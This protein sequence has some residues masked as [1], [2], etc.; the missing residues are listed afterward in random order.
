MTMND[1]LTSDQLFEW[2]RTQGQDSDPQVKTHL[3]GCDEC[4]G[5]ST[6]IAR[7]L[8]SASAGPLDEPPAAVVDRAMAIARD[9]EVRRPQ[10][11]KAWSLGR[12]MRDTLVQP[13]VAGVRGVAVGQRLLYEAD[14][15]HLDLE[16][17]AR[18]VGNVTFR[19]QGQVILPGDEPA[20]DLLAVLYRDARA[21]TGAEGDAM[22]VFVLRD[23]PHGEYRLEVW[24]METGRAIRIEPVVVG[25]DV[26]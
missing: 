18:G 12:L 1:H 13:A 3:S 5:W 19:V 25:A 11:G 14:G 15:A 26:E 21:V 6:W 7:I 4:R 10:A 2:A 17:T 8:E 20:E 9:E 22:G 23:V 16:I 24:S